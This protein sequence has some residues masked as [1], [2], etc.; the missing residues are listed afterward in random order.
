VDKKLE[1]QVALEHL[2]DMSPTPKGPFLLTG[3]ILSLSFFTG[4]ACT[5]PEQTQSAG[6][7]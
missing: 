4:H 1:K 6:G 2:G 7:L 5:I 3:A